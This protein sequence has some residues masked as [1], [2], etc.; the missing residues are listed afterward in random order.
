MPQRGRNA[1]IVIVRCQ[2]ESC[3]KRQRDE[4]TLPEVATVGG[5]R[6]HGCQQRLYWDRMLTRM[7][8]EPLDQDTAVE[9][10]RRGN[11]RIHGAPCVLG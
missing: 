1:G 9:E 8:G 11:G 10:F 2:G 7:V 3:A 5:T 6:C 4:G